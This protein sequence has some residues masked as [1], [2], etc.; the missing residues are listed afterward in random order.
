MTSPAA[1]VAGRLFDAVWRVVLYGGLLVAGVLLLSRVVDFG[2]HTAHVHFH[3]SPGTR[4][5]E[6][7][8]IAQLIILAAAIAA[9]AAARRIDRDAAPPLLQQ[10]PAAGSH[11]A[12]G[13]VWGFAAFGATIAGIAALGGYRVA[14]VALS[15][16]SLAYYGALWI[17]AAALNG[18]AENLA[19]LG[20]PLRRIGQAVGLVPAIGLMAGL[21]ALAHLGNAGENPLGLVSVFL[22][23]VSLGLAIYLTGDLWLSVGIHAGGVFAEDFVFSVPDSGVAYTGHLLKSALVGPSWL[24]GGEAG[25]E[26]SVVALPVFAVFAILLWR[27]YRR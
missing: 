6:E 12:Q 5:V 22:I 3:R 8:I 13:L 9:L 20:Y 11:F 7:L 25:P 15:G 18:A 19:L 10:R 27:A 24:T 21:F 23:G 17:A 4:P 26:A 2:L 14:G 1:S 16:P